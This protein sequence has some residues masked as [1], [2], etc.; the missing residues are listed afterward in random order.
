MF[1]TFW[2]FVG[3]IFVKGNVSGNMVRAIWQKTNQE[4]KIKEIFENE[5]VYLKIILSYLT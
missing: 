1:R 3:S 2:W 5:K 4:R